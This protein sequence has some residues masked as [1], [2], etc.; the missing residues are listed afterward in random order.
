MRAVIAE[1]ETRSRVGDV[2][3]IGA[4]V[5]VTSVAVVADDG[6]GWLELLFGSV[7]LIGLLVGL[8]LVLSAV[9]RARAEQALARSLAA[10]LPAEAARRAVVEERV[11]L[12]ADIEAAVRAAVVRMAALA[13]EAASTWRSDP[14]RPLDGIQLAGRRATTELRRML[15][16][17]RDAREASPR[18]VDTPATALV[19]PPRRDMLVAVAVGAVA[20]FEQFAYGQADMPSP[21]QPAVS[22]VLTA[23]AAAAIVTW[24]V[25]P[26][27]GAVWSAA[28]FGAGDLLSSRSRRGS[29]WSPPSA[30]W[31]GHAQPRPGGLRGTYWHCP[32][33]LSSSRCRWHA[34]T[35]RTCGSHS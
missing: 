10:T 15:G 14:T 13:D 20:V 8:R 5:A 25:A 23:A 27:L 19:V 17:L 28:A 31:P 6:A 22:V 1:D 12:A 4:A 9:R 24:R 26:W 3:I 7:M 29:G 16:L 33:W 2:G 18:Y 32:R 11:R 21:A 35:H 34:S 30:G